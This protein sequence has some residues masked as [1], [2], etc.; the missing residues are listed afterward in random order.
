MAVLPR[1]GDASVNG[2]TRDAD[3]GVAQALAWIRLLATEIGPRRPTS[4]P[5]RRAAERMR[6][7]LRESGVD[8]KLEEFLGYSTF[9]LPYGLI[10]G[11]A[12]IAAILGPGRPISRGVLGGLAAAGLATEGGLLR[13]PLSDALSRRRSQNVVATIEPRGAPARTLC[14]VC[15]LDTSR[16]GLM[17]HPL[18]AAYLT[19][20][21]SLQSA[22]VLAQG[23]APLLER[24][25]A[26]RAVLIA[27]RVA[28]ASSLALLLERELRGEDVPGANDN[29]SG[30]ATAAQLAVECAADPPAGTRVVL[31]MTGCE[32][33]SLL[34]AQAFL[35]GHD[36]SDW[37]FLN[38][39]S[40]G[41]PATLRFLRREGVIRKWDA[42]PGLVR[43]AE[44][45]RSARPDLRLDDTD[46]PAGLSYDVSP[47][48]ARGGRALSFSAQD[49]TIPNLH[50]PTD[51]F[52]NVDPDAIARA[53]EAGREM[54]AA[55]DR[56][57]AD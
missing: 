15:H 4:D 25:R 52:E 55:I 50:W 46:A 40:V 19:R 10:L 12:Q 16:S 34:G 24:F 28:I 21:I 13:T 37:L 11:A 33:A 47:V 42:D 14:I 48:L 35:R 8:A 44:S 32:E 41:G 54:I 39:D 2:H 51:V 7:E 22:A 36:T 17:F 27:A 53:L 18:L 49:A 20:W 5:E 29:A 3:P 45:V 6:D 23:A 57:E 30:A 26:G 31:L 9:G 38:F 56:G 1:T 43:A